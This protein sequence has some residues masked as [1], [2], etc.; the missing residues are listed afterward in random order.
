MEVSLVSISQFV[1]L[2]DRR[3]VSAFGLQSSRRFCL[4]RKPNW[5]Q[6]TN[7]NLR[8]ILAL[9]LT[10]FNDYEPAYRPFRFLSAP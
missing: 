1:R 10:S 8:N 5:K 3:F 6:F 4:V 7:A 2:R 9:C